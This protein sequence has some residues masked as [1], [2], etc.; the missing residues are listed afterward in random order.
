MNA[1][2]RRVSTAAAFCRI[3]DNQAL[4]SMYVYY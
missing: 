4:E 2:M 3:L 1:G